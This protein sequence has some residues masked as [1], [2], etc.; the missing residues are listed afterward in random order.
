M[1]SVFQVHPKPPLVS[2]P[3]YQS[4]LPANSTVHF[5]GEMSLRNGDGLHREE[6]GRH[7]DA[8]PHA[9]SSVTSN[10][11]AVT[12]PSF[13]VPM[14]YIFFLQQRGELRKRFRILTILPYKRDNRHFNK[15]PL[16]NMEGGPLPQRCS[17][18]I[19]QCHVTRCVRKTSQPG[20]HRMNE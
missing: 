7:V 18:G 8:V 11:F 20:N 13:D 9:Y 3:H 16:R 17:S 10:I 5:I 19:R 15:I 6:H 12:Q 4:P 14:R 2:F 1:P